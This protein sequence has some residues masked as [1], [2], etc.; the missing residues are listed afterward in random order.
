[1]ATLKDIA[2]MAGVSQG[3]VSNVINGRGNVSSS[4]IK[5]VEAAAQKLGY[6]VNERAKLLRKGSSNIIALV[7]PNLQTKKYYDMYC[8]VSNYVCKK[9]YSVSLYFTEDLQER[10]LEQI[11][12]M[13][14]DMVARVIVVSCLDNPFPIY[15]KAGFAD[16]KVLF[17]ERQNDKSGYTIGFDY[18]L[19]GREVCERIMKNHTSVYILQAHPAFMDNESFLLGFKKQAAMN[20]DFSYHIMEIDTNQQEIGI[21]R[22]LSEQRDLSCICVMEY[23]LAEMVY[24]VARTFFPKW[25][26]LSVFTISG[27]HTLPINDFHKYELDYGMLGH[28]AAHRIIQQ[29]TNQNS[30]GES[31]ILPNAGFRDWDPEQMVC[32]KNEALHLLMLNG[33]EAV[34]VQELS[35]IYTDKTGVKIT[36][37][38][39]SYDEIFEILNSTG[40]DVFDILRIDITFLSWFSGRLLVPLTELDPGI[41]SVLPCFL[42]GVAKRY[43]TIGETLYALPFSP[44]MQLLFYRRDLFDSTVLRR[45]YQEEYKCE[46]RPPTSFDEYNRIARFFTKK[47][48]SNSPTEYGTSLMLGSIGVAGSEFMARVLETRRN[49]YADDGTVHLNDV[50]CVRALANLVELQECAPPYLS[51]W[52]TDAA[53]DF[54]SGRTAMAILY[55]NYASDLLHGGV[56]INEKIGY[57]L[58]P[59]NN[60]VLGG[61]SLGISKTSKKQQLALNFLKWLCS[62]SV[63]SATS[64]LGGA[65][66]CKVAYTNHELLQRFPWLELAGNS[67]V[68]ADGYRQ[69]PENQIP[70]NER[71]FLNIIGMAVK[72]ACNGSLSSEEALNWAQ[73]EYERVL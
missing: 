21:I 61:A 2:I 22:L 53:K 55:N 71:Q 20:R 9:G 7:L 11:S 43:S 13:C 26:Q 68:L 60:P 18:E 72:N 48:N 37:A 49:L 47:Y 6:T 65:S 27:V 69:P 31:M 29:N 38:V 15:Q 35:R 66:G 40:G 59:G 4:K 33:P 46:L 12:R 54:A 64:F 24:S 39:Y 50:Q 44:S 3:T 25:N 14:S 45:L 42:D 52:W 30:P 1:M 62:E 67:F 73:K 70:F 16:D 10:E 28:N 5:L 34:A 41:D 8:G 57:T 17:V 58:V 32:A 63:S 36:T 56:A 23:K 19:A 51:A